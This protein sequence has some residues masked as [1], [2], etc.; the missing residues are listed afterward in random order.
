[1]VYDS[2]LGAWDN[3]LIKTYTN[4]FSCRVYIQV[5][6]ILTEGDKWH[7]KKIS[8]IQHSVRVNYS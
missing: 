1:M 2:F 6:E 7:E 8:L 4:T 5:G 3:L